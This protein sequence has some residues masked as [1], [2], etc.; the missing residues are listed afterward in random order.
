M[1]KNIA[2]AAAAMMAVAAQPST[3]CQRAATNSPISLGRLATTI[4]A[5]MIGTTMTPF[6]TAPKPAP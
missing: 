5:A 2:M 4:I 1:R 6:T 3:R